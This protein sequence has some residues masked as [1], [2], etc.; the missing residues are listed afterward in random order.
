MS[1]R[2]DMGGSGHDAIRHVP[3]PGELPHDPRVDVH[4][5]KGE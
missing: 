4:A 3:H 2:S 1:D 5:V